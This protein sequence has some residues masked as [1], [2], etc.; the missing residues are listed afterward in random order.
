MGTR[1]L[2]NKFTSGE[3]DPKFL[4]EVDYDGYRKAGRKLR[5]VITI[6]QGGVTRRFGSLWQDVILD[7]GQ[8]GNYVTNINQVRLIEYEYINGDLLDIIIRPDATNVVAFDIYNDG[9]FQVS[10]PAIGSTYTPADIRTIRWVKDYGRLILL[11]PNHEPEI[12]QFS[13]TLTASSIRLA[14]FQNFPSFDYTYSD[15][16]STLPT[17]NTPYWSPGVTFTPNA[18]NATTITASIAVFTSNHVNGIYVSTDLQNPGIFRIN[19]INGGGTVATGITIELF[20]ATSAIPGTLSVLEER[21][22]ND[23]AIIGGAPAGPNRGWPGH[24]CFYQSRLAL[25]GSPALPGTAFASNVRAYFDFDDTESIDSYGWSVEIGVTGNDVIQ[26]IIPSKSLIM[27]GNKGPASTSILLNEPTTPTNAF[28]NTQGTEGSRNMNGVIIDNQ[29]IY[30]DR[31]GNTIW[32]MAYEIPDTGYN[33]S[34]ASI[35]STQLIR[36]PVWADIFDPD[37][38]DGR[39]YMLVN[40]DGSMA[41]YNTILDENIKAWTLAQTTGSYI[42]VS[43]TVNQCKTLVRRKI[44][45]SGLGVNGTA[46][47][48]YTVDSTFSAFRN[49]TL[50]VNAPTTTPVFINQGDYILIGSEIE[51]NQISVTVN[52]AA[53]LSILPVFQFLTNTGEWETFTPTVETTV[54]FQITGTIQW[55]HAQVANWQSQT[56]NF[57]DKF[58]DE[59]QSLYWIRIQRTQLNL[60]VT[61][62]IDGLLLDTQDVIYLEKM[63][64]SVENDVGFLDDLVMD[65]QITA[66]ADGAGVVPGLVQLAGQNAFF[67]ANGF[68]IGIFYVDSTATVDVG[69]PNATIIA[70]LDY[71]VN[72]TPMPI[73]ALLQNGISVYEPAHVKYVYVDFYESLGVTFQGQNLPQVVP[74]QFMSQEVPQPMS[75][76]YKVPVYGGWDPREIFVISQSYPAP[77]TILAIS[78]TIEVSP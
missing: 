54:G 61:P 75:G 47:A 76:Y 57:T 48:I 74:G 25:G 73:I 22:W 45:T 20:T 10:I 30:A 1:D 42:D 46:N 40:S 44:S 68:P 71:T 3:L 51:F 39:Y 72:V 18:T 70:G 16:P 34:N 77:M 55:M 38:I 65:C 12:L 14:D 8:T 43:C 67:F 41:M 52:T 53:S 17:P 32:S 26:D 2:I 66:I 21:A 69:V 29:I 62:I 56:I 35:L 78:Y 15:D 13:P 28:M 33:I 9:L 60:M 31:A 50:P 59:L 58:Y 11:H 6:P 4:A 19:S 63:A 64:H 27:L 49:I 5:N 23:G 24:G 36:G 37:D 7:S